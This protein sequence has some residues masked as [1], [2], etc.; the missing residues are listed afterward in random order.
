MA[1]VLAHQLVPGDHI[2]LADE[3]EQPIVRVDEVN[4]TEP[5][6]NGLSD[7]KLVL[8]QVPF[9]DQQIRITFASNEHIRKATVQHF[10]GAPVLG[11]GP[12]GAFHR[13]VFV[14]G[15]SP[16]TFI[17]SCLWFQHPKYDQIY[18]DILWANAQPGRQ[19]TISSFVVAHTR[20]LPGPND[21]NPND[22]P[23]PPPRNAFVAY[24]PVHATTTRANTPTRE[25]GQIWAP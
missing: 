5:N 3:D 2:L 7:I 13:K 20:A 18:Q 23:L 15:P 16:Y 21:P 14:N 1:I 6:D 4:V 10:N 12:S 17:R 19:V 24:I 11:L 22:L 25:P 8:T 9:E